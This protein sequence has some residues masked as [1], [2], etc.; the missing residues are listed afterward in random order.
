MR[1]VHIR[2][3]ECVCE[4]QPIFPRFRLSVR[5]T[6]NSNTFTLTQDTQQSMPATDDMKLCSEMENKISERTEGRESSNGQ[7]QKKY[8]KTLIWW[9]SKHWTCVAMVFCMTSPFFRCHDP[10]NILHFDVLFSLRNCVMVWILTN[11]IISC[12]YE[13]HAIMSPLAFDWKRALSA[14]ASPSSFS[15]MPVTGLKYD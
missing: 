2:V 11:T 9:A 8:P 5:L 7:Q 3:C 10:N 6:P 1:A 14:L 13:I 12:C 15:S 4:S